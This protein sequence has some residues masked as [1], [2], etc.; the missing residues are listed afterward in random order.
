MK[1]SK[2]ASSRVT[3]PDQEASAAMAESKTRNRGKAIRSNAME[4]A[5]IRKP[6][7]TQARAIQGHMRASGQR[8]QA[9]RDAR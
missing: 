1:K 7:K 2:K 8:R 3:A 9:K 5:A 6:N 4:N